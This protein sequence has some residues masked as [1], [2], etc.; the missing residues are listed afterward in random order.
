MQNLVS[1]IVPC[2]NAESYIKKC[3]ESILLQTYINIE[4]IIINDGS[5]DNSLNICQELQKQDKRIKIINQENKGAS[6]ARLEGIKQAKGE[7]LSF[8]DSDD[9]IEP[10]YIELLVYA[11][12]KH[13]T[14]IAACNMIK[15]QACEAPKII[16]NN[17]S[18]ILN[19]EELHKRFFNYEFWGFWGKI[20]K[21]DVFENIYFPKAT[22]NEDYVVMAQLFNKYKHIAYIETPLYHYLIHNNESLSKTRLSLKMMDEWTNKHWCYQ[23]YKN[24]NSIWI[25]HAEA[26]AAETCSKLIRIIGN[27]KEYKIQKQTMISFLK[28]HIY[29]LMFNESL[30]FGV[31]IMIIFQLISL[32]K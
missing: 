30:V 5:T 21:K 14:S 17:H 13:H 3:L 6:I 23:Y 16:R 19:E 8:V 7:Y 1:I 22:I 10:N 32:K 26:Q 24:N 2:Y 28:K 25:R 31:K 11:I 27:H 29:T 12:E 20:Y 4:I 18:R 15:H 9:F